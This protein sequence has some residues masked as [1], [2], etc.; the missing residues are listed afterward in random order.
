MGEGRSRGEGD[1]LRPAW[2]ALATYRSISSTYSAKVRYRRTSTWAA[3]PAPHPGEQAARF[4]DRS[5]FF[6]A[7]MCSTR[8]G[9]LQREIAKGRQFQFDRQHNDHLPKWDAYFSY[10][11]GRS[12]AGERRGRCFFIQTGV[13]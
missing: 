10:S 6:L 4:W 13:Q 2:T 7:T 1:N 3:L 5:L 11:A 8:R 9:K 12:L